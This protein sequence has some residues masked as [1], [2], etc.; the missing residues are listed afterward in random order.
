MEN[1]NAIF[2]GLN[3]EQRDAVAHIDGPVLI[4]AGAGSGKTKVLTCRIANILSREVPSERVLSLTFTKKAAGEMKERV[5][6]MVGPRAAR[7]L[8]MG[9]FHS[10]FIRFLRDYA[11]FLGYPENFTIYDTSDSLSLVKTCIKEMDIDDKVYKPKTVL[12]RISEAKN[13][14]V[15]PAAYYANPAASDRDRAAKMP[16]LVEIYDLYWKKCREAGVMDFDDILFEMNI[17]LRDSPEALEEISSRFDYILVDEYQDTNRAQYLILKKLAAPHRRICVVG[18]DSQSIYAFRGARIE[19]ILNFKRDY[20]ECRIF[21]LEQNYRSTQTIVNAANSL[22]EH[23]SGR[24]PKKCF[25]EGEEGDLIHLFRAYSEDEEAALTVSSIVDVIRR[26]GAQYQDFA[27]LYRTNAQS[28]VLEEALRRRNIPY[29]IYSGNSFFDRAEI[30]DMMAYFKLAVNPMDNESFKRAVNKPARGI[31]DTSLGALMSAA[32]DNNMSLM[33]AAYIPDI[34]KYG[35]K[36]AAVARIRVFT[37]MMLD[38]HNRSLSED[39]YG[40]CRNIALESGMLLSLRSDLSVEGQARCANV[41]ELLN[42]VKAYIE[43]RENEVYEDVIAEY[44]SADGT[45]AANAAVD[46]LVVKL[47]DYL[48]NVALLSAVDVDDDDSNNKV[49]LMTVHS[50][51]GLE[52]PYVYIVGMEENLFPGGGN[53]ARSSDVEEERRLFYVAVTRAMKSVKLSFCSQRM[54]NGKTEN[55]DPSRFIRDIDPQYIDNPLPAAVH[56]S[57]TV[58]FRRMMPSASS[59]PSPSPS[60]SPSAGVPRAGSPVSRTFSSRGTSSATGHGSA[61][62][63]GNASGRVPGRNSA[64]APRVPDAAFEASPVS[65]LREGQRIEHNR[66]GFGQIKSIVDDGGLKAVIEFDSYGEKVLLLKYAKI[67]I[68]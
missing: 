27:V 38:F 64:P 8:V 22:I 60:P 25:S 5:A 46:T 48:E 18:D 58:D 62:N 42:S 67:R 4:V 30:K 59:A 51:K 44:G 10:V 2:E 63:S 34:E 35:L 14:L 24:I 55:N 9:T 28:R 68:V 61:Q 16:R 50:S 66:F 36:A 52:F 21:R 19:N 12:A 6:D 7:R 49:A 1:E 54:R 17:L 3:P 31:G 11:A 13:S 15:T 45:E 26:E 29:M 23:N 43:Q 39:A 33:E 32:A 53:L 37:N 65:E 40:L 41:D 56:K 57:G 47:T 20:P